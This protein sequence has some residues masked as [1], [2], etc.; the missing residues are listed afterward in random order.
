VV[1]DLG[2]PVRLLLNVVRDRGN[3]MTVDVRNRSGAPAIGAKVRFDLGDR[4]LTRWV[5]TDSSYL[6]AQDHRVHAGLGELRVI[7]EVEIVWPDG[8]VRRF[9]DIEAGRI[10]KVLPEED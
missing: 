9:Q 1:Q 10:L 8:S 5:H 2:A 3:W 6:T 4:T 7:P